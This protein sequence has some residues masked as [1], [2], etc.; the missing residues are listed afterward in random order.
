MSNDVT[1]RSVLDKI[2]H[3]LYEANMWIC[4]ACFLA[5][6][7]SIVT[8]VIGRYVFKAAPIWVEQASL[9]AMVW[10]GFLSLSIATRDHGH[11]NVDIINMIVPKSVA[12]ALD[13]L[14]HVIVIVYS[15]IMT[16][17][18]IDLVK[19][20][21][22]VRFS[23]IPISEAFNFLPLVIAGVSCVYASAYEIYLLFRKEDTKE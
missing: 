16:I 21:L 10:I 1:K 3:Y 8:L 5:Q 19:L 7:I 2:S 20:T 23:S 6:G 15:V 14:G 17:G 9:L 18:G 4:V 12:K 11:I 22:R 13:V